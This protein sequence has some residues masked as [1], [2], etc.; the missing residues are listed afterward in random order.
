MMY[1]NTIA[2]TFSTRL[3]LLVAV[4][5]GN[6]GLAFASSS[7]TIQDFS[8]KAGETK[9]VAVELTSAAEGIY[10]LEG[11]VSV[12]AGLEIV[13][14]AYGQGFHAQVA[15]RAQSARVS[16]NP[17][18]GLFTILGLGKTA[19][20]GTSGAIFKFKV[21]A[22]E[23][24]E[25]GSIRFSGLTA[26]YAD[27]ATEQ[28][29]STA[30]AVTVEQ[31][32]GGDNPD[33]PQPQPGEN[34]ISF[35]QSTIK[36]A[37]GESAT[38]QLQLTN[39]DAFT[40]MSGYIVASEGITVTAVQNT[41]RLVGQF[42]YLEHSG[43]FSM[44][45]AINGNTGTIINI[46]IQAADDF[47]GN[48]T[49]TVR[50]FRVTDAAANSISLGT[51][52]AVISAVFPDAPFLSL[53]F[54]DEANVTLG[55][56]KSVD[57]PV[58]VASNQSL[59]GFK[60][61]LVLP[62]GIT[63][64]VKKGDLISGDPDY[65]AANG[66]IMYM[67]PVEDGEGPLFILTLTADEEFTADAELQLTNINA[68]SGDASTALYAEDV[69]LTIK[70]KDEAAKA[71]ADAI[72]DA[73]QKKLDDAVATI[74]KDYPAA[75]EDL[76]DDEAG[77]QGEIDALK[78]QIED[79]YADNTLDPEKIQEI[80]DAISQEIDDLLEKAKAK[81]EAIDAKKAL[82]AEIA[83]LQQKL[84]AAEET[85]P[86]GIPADAKKALEDEADAIQDMIDAL[87]ADAEKNGAIDAAKK[88]AILDAI[89]ALKAEIAKWLRGDVDNDGDVDMA[90]FY[91]LKKLIS[92]EKTPKADEDANAFYR[93]DA[94]ADGEINVGDLQ[95]IL[96][97]CTG[98]SANG[99]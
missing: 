15:T 89:D 38:L 26:T 56:G 47:S 18:S 84:D 97:I 73:L 34:G 64:E 94:N 92:E 49:V 7:V 8:I 29:T 5:L 17:V 22:S 66:N 95:G 2:K 99:K 11:T 39:A 88:Q 70:A 65:V 12:P 41:S 90:D 46:A 31:G 87:K 51:T 75:Q 42:D 96:N 1:F 83:E 82:D 36:L 72:A 62:A 79:A 59:T 50:D 61:K 14:N 48:A 27:G 6:A 19:F 57:V 32:Q 45:G 16:L 21:K 28:S 52:Q 44:I 3:A 69:T 77:I 40:G 54:E 10:Q 78:Q 23:T 24:F 37:S 20:S 60:A 81:Q 9:E 53:S 33:V 58:F 85:I 76:K 4:L 93:C 30:T 86:A 25:G 71:E 98:L 35:A 91:A 80:A 68:T 43:K 13:Q 63:A 55:A 67:G 74:E